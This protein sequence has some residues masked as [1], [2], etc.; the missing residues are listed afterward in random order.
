MIMQL[1]SAL[2]AFDD[3][4]TK[5]AARLPQGVGPVMSWS[6]KI[7]LPPVGITILVT[8]LVYFVLADIGRSALTVLLVLIGTGIV[9]LIKRLVHR[10]RPD[11][12]YVA[13]KNPRG[14]SFPSGHAADALLV[15]GLLDYFSARYLPLTEAGVLIAV[16]TAFILV[17]SVSR[18]WLGAHFPSDI[19]GGWIIG[20]LWLLAAIAITQS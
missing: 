10:T 18:V 4:V 8:A 12:V 2:S 9:D 6:S 5:L 1:S 19:I 20:G 14:Y 17:V 16:F 15:Y 13:T 7:G 3:A 11:T